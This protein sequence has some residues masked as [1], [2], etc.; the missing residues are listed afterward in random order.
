MVDKVKKI[1][2][3]G[4][5][6]DWDA[7]KVHVITHTLHYGLGAFEGIR[8]YK[9]ADGSTAIFRLKEHLERLYDSCRL[10][11]IEP[12]F[13]RDQV[14]EACV[15]ILRENKMDEAYLR[16]VVFV[17]DGAM[18]VYAPDN[19]IRTVIVAWRWG[20]YLGK[21]ALDQ[22]IRAKISSWA[23]HHLH[24]SLAKGKIMG[25]Y[26]NST[27]AKREAKMAGYDEAILMDVTGYVSEGSGE[28]LFIVKKGKLMTPPL[29]ASIL[30]G[31]TRDSI[32]TLAKEE[33]IPLSEEMITRDQLYLADEVFFTGTAAEV[34]PIR[35]IDDRK[36]GDG[37]VGPLT[38]R[39]QQ[40]YFEVVRGTDN[41]HPEWLTR[42][43][44]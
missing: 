2:L 39:L 43:R 5:F 10:V 30:E 20:A 16:P 24:V 14:H 29:S 9:R 37:K 18:G 33:G 28:N 40:R 35:E 8:A 25:Q 7:A 6:V 44:L 3:E 38:K 12:R 34:T 15:Q 36:I 27:L 23:R 4:E 42:V 32:I 1:W 11:M 41:S 22:G 26:T 13:T 21:T 19:P 31:I 17:G